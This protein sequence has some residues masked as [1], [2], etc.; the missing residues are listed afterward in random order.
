M[1]CHTAAATSSSNANPN[2]PAG[3][4]MVP[5]NAKRASGSSHTTVD[6]DS[7][8]M[9]MMYPNYLDPT[10]SQYLYHQNPYT[11]A[12]PPQHPSQQ[13]PLMGPQAQHYYGNN[14]SPYDM[15]E[16]TPIDGMIMDERLYYPPAMH[17]SYPNQ[18][19]MPQQPHGQFL[20]SYPQASR[21]SSHMYSNKHENDVPSLATRQHYRHDDTARPPRRIS[22]VHARSNSTSQA[23][24]MVG[25]AEDEQGRV[26]SYTN[27]EFQNNYRMMHK[28]MSSSF[29][30]AV[31]QNPGYHPPSASD[32][33][34]NH[35]DDASL[36]HV[37]ST[38]LS[39]HVSSQIH[40]NLD[41]VGSSTA[42]PP[43]ILPSGFV[44]VSDHMH[45]PPQN[46]Q[47]QEHDDYSKPGYLHHSRNNN[48]MDQSLYSPATRQSSSYNNATH[49]QIHPT[50]NISSTTGDH[51]Y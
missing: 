45:P 35:E 20:N 36:Y 4:V 47:Q 46:P 50:H 34:E 41:T 33:Y 11:G 10:A 28:G 37:P 43:G 44:D 39:H 48:I 19:T 2:I 42:G 22:G 40:D 5:A 17:G 26:Q 31:P 13:Y 51:S 6:N 8:A 25:T 12:R 27:H 1:T 21:E 29:R 9:M 38:G 16:E 14:V 30:P 24:S 18:Y 49:K 15:Y 7:M 32:G 3:S 23:P